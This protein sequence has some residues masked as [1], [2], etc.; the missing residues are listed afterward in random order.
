[1]TSGS[2][3]QH[4]RGEHALAAER[5]VFVLGAGFTR[6]FFP[7]AP[8]VVDDYQAA[9]LAERVRHLQY[10]SRILDWERSRETGG[11]INI[12]RL[13]TRLDGGMPY[14]YDQGASTELATLLSELKKAFVKRIED[15]RT[16]GEHKDD[17]VAFADYCVNSR[18]TCITTNYD[19]LLDE[20]LY[21]VSD[22]S[23]IRGVPDKPYW[24]PDGGYGFF[25][26]PSYSTVQDTD[27][28]MDV[29]VSMHLLKLH[30]SINWR[31]RRGSQQPH[32]VDA[33][34]H[35]EP[36]FR[37][38]GGYEVTDRDVVHLHLDPEP[39]IVPP[40]LLKS[41][42]LEQPILRLVWHLAYRALFQAS[43]VAFIG[44]SLP[45]TDIAVN[46]LFFEALNLLPRSTIDVVNLASDKA[47]RNR[48]RE[49]YEYVFG[50]IPAKQ[51]SFDGAL[52]W[53]RKLVAG[54]HVMPS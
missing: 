16:Q 2:Q 24:H 18:V 50:Q 26:R 15:T 27:V 5:T 42:I 7:A 6:A 29:S 54:G 52:E 11:R 17:L 34:M 12:E 40:V 25:C 48:I 22:V 44:Y 28:F 1:M 41:A 39:F 23:N 21:E 51:F 33:V 13:M 10:A 46:H 4:D 35:H 19:D 9:E 45:M 20:A 3:S 53:S 47:D 38:E 14:D 32:T 37:A 8:L 31:P 36:W 49:S 30:G 43:R